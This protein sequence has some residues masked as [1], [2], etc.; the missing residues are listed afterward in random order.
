[1]IFIII[2]NLLIMLF[3][4][5]GFNGGEKQ[6][7]KTQ[8]GLI[9]LVANILGM[10]LICGYALYNLLQTTGW[11]SLKEIVTYKLD[12]IIYLIVIYAII[13]LNI[14]NKQ[15]SQKAPA[16]KVVIEQVSE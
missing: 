2:A 5:S 1:M 16:P 10:Y 9:V 3:I 11:D 8:G 4:S 12:S 14:M 15:A 13:R 6:L 7:V